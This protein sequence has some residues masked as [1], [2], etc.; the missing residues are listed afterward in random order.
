M[1]QNKRSHLWIIAGA[2]LSIASIVV[3]CE[4][5]GGDGEEER[6]NLRSVS[7]A[8][9]NELVQPTQPTE[10]PPVGALVTAA[11]YGSPGGPCDEVVQDCTAANVECV[12]NL[13]ANI[14]SYDADD[15]T[16]STNPGFFVDKN[17]ESNGDFFGQLPTVVNAGPA[18]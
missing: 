9:S 1:N 2:L 16:D 6:E 4:G 5:D 11:T 3:A 13:C 7:Q 14:P 10:T 8:L 17:A 18:Y 15:G 12:D